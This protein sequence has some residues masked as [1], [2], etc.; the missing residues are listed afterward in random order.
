VPLLQ[1]VQSALQGKSLH[2]LDEAS[3]SKSKA[4]QG[5]EILVVEDNRVN[6]MI[7]TLLL[8]KLGCRVEVA[9]N[10]VEACNALERRSFDLILMDCQMPEMDGF[11]ATR[12]IRSRENGG[13]RTPIIALTA[14][15][16]KEERDQCYQAGMDGFLSKPIS[17]DELKAALE[18]WLAATRA[19]GPQAQGQAETNPLTVRRRHV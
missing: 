8:Q 15:V 7:A 2:A 10:G 12:T 17:N 1:A 9:R 5:A 11:E 6:Q 19:Q 3:R 18:S 16:L 14:G 13:R 4:T